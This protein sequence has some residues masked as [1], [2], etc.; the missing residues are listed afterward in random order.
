MLNPYYELPYRSGDL[1]LVV[2]TDGE[3]SLDFFFDEANAYGIMG[4][5]FSPTEGTLIPWHVI[6]RLEL[7]AQAGDN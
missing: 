1:L 6:Q 4:G 2:R 7:K 3:M 5:R